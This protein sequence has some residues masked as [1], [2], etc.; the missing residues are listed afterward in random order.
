MLV[1]LPRT[2]HANGQEEVMNKNFAW[3][4]RL[5]EIKG[6]NKGGTLHYG[7]WK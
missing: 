4:K 6:D 2:P 7:I 3:K 5:I 1:L